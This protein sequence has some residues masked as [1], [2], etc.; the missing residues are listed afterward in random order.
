[1]FQSK[2]IFQGKQIIPSATFITSAMVSG[3]GAVG[4]IPRQESHPSVWMEGIYFEELCV[5]TAWSK[6]AKAPSTLIMTWT[7]KC[8]TLTFHAAFRSVTDGDEAFVL[9]SDHWFFFYTRACTHTLKDFKRGSLPALAVWTQA[10]I[11]FV[12]WKKHNFSLFLR[13]FQI[14]LISDP[15]W[16]PDYWK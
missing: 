11:C 4:M 14:S 8:W 3:V 12:N 13:W 7:L 16:H 2:H 1:M 10:D 15:S 6:L 9:P 5:M